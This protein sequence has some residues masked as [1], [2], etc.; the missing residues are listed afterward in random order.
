MSRLAAMPA[1]DAVRGLGL[2]AVLQAVVLG[3]HGRDLDAILE[4][5]RERVDA[6]LAQAREL[7]A[8]L[9]DDRRLVAL[10]RGFVSLGHAAASLLARRPNVCR[11]ERASG[12]G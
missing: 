1:R 12:F 10:R 2:L 4:L 7:R 6:A 8:A 3:A 5:V 9:G 11:C